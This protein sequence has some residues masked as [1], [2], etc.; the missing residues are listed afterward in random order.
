MTTRLLNTLLIIFL[1]LMTKYLG[2]SGINSLTQKVSIKR[3]GMEQ[4]AQTLGSV[5]K[6]ILNVIILCV[7]G[8]TLLS[9]WG[10]NVTPI[11]TGAGI[12]SLAVGFGSQALVRDFVTGIFIL[13]E[14][15]YNIGD[16]IRAAGVE[17]TVR[18][19]KLR[20]TTLVGDDGVVHIIPNSSISLISKLPI[21]DKK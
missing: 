15:Q 1:A 17:G 19:I 20:T 16:R 2:N 12:V 14:N 18:E 6:S 8:V 11:I 9:E 21:Y 10:I 4:R 5:L 7:T 3:L 13:T